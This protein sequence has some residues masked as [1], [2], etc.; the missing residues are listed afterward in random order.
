M[1]FERV[2]LEKQPILVEKTGYAYRYGFQACPDK[3]TLLRG[4][5]S[6]SRK[7]S[8]EVKGEGNSVNYK[9]RMHDPR[10]G[11]FFCGGSF[12]FRVSK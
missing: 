8:G 9:Y 3:F 6:D 12:R 4:Q 11:K 5:E 2:L 10:L 7:L 1:L